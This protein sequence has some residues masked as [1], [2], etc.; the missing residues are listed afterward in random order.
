MTTRSL[1][2][3]LRLYEQHVD[4][5]EIIEPDENDLDSPERIRRQRAEGV[6]RG[7]LWMARDHDD[8]L[9]YVLVTA[10]CDDPRMA[11]VI[12]LSND[13]RMETADSLVIEK[14]APL[15]IPMVAWPVFRTAIPISLLFKPLK[16]FAPAT[17]DAIE[18]NDPAKADPNDVIRHGTDPD[19]EMSEAFDE[20]DDTALIMIV[21]HARC[22]DLPELGQLDRAEDGASDDLEAYG[23]ALQDVLGLKPQIR[24]AVMRGQLALNVS[25]QR[26]MAKAG[27]PKAPQK[28]EAIPDD[29]LILAEQPEFYE[30]AEQINP[31]NPQQARLDMARKA[32]YGLAARTTGH[33]T[34]ALRGAFLK[35]AEQLVKDNGG[36]Q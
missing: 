15:E 18:G 4:D 16:E 11:M 6:R 31:A 2:D 10:L 7:Q 36:A 1:T 19:D 9:S 29:Y 30:I 35:A 13:E 23:K 25:Q 21:W 8:N 12:P 26:K 22:A 34:A 3:M 32:A 20:R 33:G 14:G 24:L 27:F 17:V 5:I 28:Q